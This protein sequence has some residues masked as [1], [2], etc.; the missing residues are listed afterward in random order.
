MHEMKTLNRSGSLF[1][2]YGIIMLVLSTMST[3]EAFSEVIKVSNN[4]SV[5]IAVRDAKEGDIVDLPAGKF[6]GRVTITKS[7][8]LR[9]AGKDKTRWDFV[10]VEKREE[11]KKDPGGIK[12]SGENITLT[13]E[14]LHLH[15]VKNLNT[16][17]LNKDTQKNSTLIIKDC[18][19]TSEERSWPSIYAQNA[20]ITIEKTQFENV[21]SNAIYADRGCNLKV[22][23]C[24]FKKGGGNGSQ[25]RI[26]K[27]N[28][29]LANN[30]FENVKGMCVAVIGGT[31]EVL[32]E[33]CQFTGSGN[34]GSPAIWISERASVLATDCTFNN[35]N[36]TSIIVENMA[37][38][39]I[40]GKSLFS[41]NE[42]TRNPLIVIR[43]GEV[44]I[45]GPNS[46]DNTTFDNIEK[47]GIK[48]ENNG[49]LNANGC[50]FQGNTKKAVFVDCKKG[51][52]EMRKCDFGDN[53]SCIIVA[54]GKTFH[55]EDC[56]FGE[57]QSNTIQM[58][59]I[60][61]S[62]PM[63]IRCAFAGSNDSCIEVKGSSSLIIRN[64]KF[65]DKLSEGHSTEDPLV[66]ARNGCNIAIIE[67]GFS[68]INRT[69]VKAVKQS[70]I[71][72]EKCNFTG[73]KNGTDYAICI[74]SKSKAK[75]SNCTFDWGNSKLLSAK[76][77]ESVTIEGIRSKINKTENTQGG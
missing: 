54:E 29:E 25:I 11:E 49:N 12:I 28:A 10:R 18:K 52:L 63:I 56:G 55:L 71:N 62:N 39:E 1:L 27:C 4:E 76:D 7:L 19:F 51:N 37:K 16:I 72:L 2:F 26:E 60:W 34:R 67:S 36:G 61:A 3:K 73:N 38:L 50:R 33:T 46:G 30:T 74:E 9:G 8:T 15:S 65:K 32:L 45:G 64:C 40:K 48:I 31:A 47:C 59:K 23:N 53:K 17:N 58:K 41:V 13:V 69:C 14:N 24:K 43:N 5:Q 66:R 44:T 35:T 70:K 68:D 77:C 20:K 6:A 42:D 75:I 57:S 21:V 22:E